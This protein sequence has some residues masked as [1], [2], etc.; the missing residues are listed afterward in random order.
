MLKNFKENSVILNEGDLDKKMYKVVSG[1]VEVYIGYR[2]ESETIIGILSEGKYFGEL[3][4]FVDEPAIYTV[5]AYSDCL[6]L[7]IERDELGVFAKNNYLDL[8]A[9]MKNMTMSTINLKAS[10]DL[11]NQDILALSSNLEKEK[12]VNE[13]KRRIMTSDVRKQ[14]LKYNMFA[15]NSDT[16]LKTN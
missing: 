13:I 10:I 12:N 15:A 8:L 6:V 4:A 5:V 1:K 14:Y 3:G 2:T 11:L 16:Q 7:E 9:I